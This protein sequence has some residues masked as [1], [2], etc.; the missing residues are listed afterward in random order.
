MESEN[1]EIWVDGQEKT[2]VTQQN[3]TPTSENDRQRDTVL[4]SVALGPAGSMGMMQIGLIFREMQ[5]RLE[6]SKGGNTGRNTD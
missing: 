3:Q 2:S 4:L 5:S 6:K 1:A